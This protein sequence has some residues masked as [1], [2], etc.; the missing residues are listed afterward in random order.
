MRLD[1]PNFSPAVLG[2]IVRAAGRCRSFQEAADGLADLAE[3]AISGR[4]TGRIAHEIGEELRRARQQQVEAFQADRLRPEVAVA[5]E[6]AVVESDGG[7]L[8]TRAEDQGRGVHD[9]AWRED[10][11]AHLMTMTCPSQDHDPHPALP[12][13]FTE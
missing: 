10:K 8:Q 9:P 12:R 4:Q 1:S 6:L 3:V 5:P 11:F 13:C 2:K 7:R